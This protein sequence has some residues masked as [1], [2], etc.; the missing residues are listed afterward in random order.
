MRLGCGESFKI[1]V[2]IHFST[3]SVNV[4]GASVTYEGLEW[5][6]DV[7]RVAAFAMLI[8]VGYSEAVS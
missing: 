7:K 5:T 1:G 4:L 3:N 6:D 2:R 8:Q